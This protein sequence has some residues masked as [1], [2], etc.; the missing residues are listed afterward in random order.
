MSAVNVNSSQYVPIHSKQIRGLAFSNRPDGLLLSAA[1]DHTL[2]LTRWVLRQ[3]GCFPSPLSSDEWVDAPPL[4]LQRN[5]GY[6]LT[7]WYRY[8]QGRMGSFQAT[9]TEVWWCQ[10]VF[11]SFSLTTNT[12]VMTYNAGRPVWSCCWCLDNT[13]YIYAGLV[14]GS[15]LVYDL[16]D[17]TYHV[18]ELVSEKYRYSSNFIR[19]DGSPKS[20]A[21]KMENMGDFK[22]LF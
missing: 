4:I 5:S 8:L 16:R 15:V 12:V 17:T 13:N 22:Y 2:K 7:F 20:W 1:L 14:N 10:L 21:L 9:H 18:Q 6:I 11:P 19:V 3:Q